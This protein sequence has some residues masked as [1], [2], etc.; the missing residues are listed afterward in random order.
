MRIYICGSISGID[1]DV[2]FGIFEK[3][4][5]ELSKKYPNAKI[6]N[7]MKE[8]PTEEDKKW[9][10]YLLEDL[11]IVKTCTHIN[12]IN[13]SCLASSTGTLIES[14]YASRIGLQRI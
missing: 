14:L 13:D 5:M 7:P 12:M 11:E 6:L 9:E 2:A 4:E 1:T 8:V 10:D 3:R